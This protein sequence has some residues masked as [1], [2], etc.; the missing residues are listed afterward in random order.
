[1]AA[2]AVAAFVAAP[3]NAQQDW[4]RGNFEERQGAHRFGE[5]CIHRIVSQGFAH[6]N[7]FG[8]GGRDAARKAE[9]RAIR[10]WENRVSEKSD[11]SSPASTNLRVKPTSACAEVRNSSA[12]SARIP[13]ASGMGL[14]MDRVRDMSQVPATGVERS[15]ASD[16][17]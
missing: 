7:F 10:S 4:R 17:I 5:F 14:I 16:L 9:A 15:I 12:P 1:M 13:A 2:A 11:R 3:A 8:G 6:V